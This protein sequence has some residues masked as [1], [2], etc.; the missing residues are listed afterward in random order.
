MAV[1]FHSVIPSLSTQVKVRG[2]VRFVTFTAKDRPYGYGYLH[3]GDPEMIAAIKKHPYFGKYITVAQEDKPAEQEANKVS[4]ST[5]QESK[6]VRKKED[7]EVTKTQEAKEILKNEYD[8]PVE[9]IRSKAAAHVAAE[10]VG[11]SF[12]NL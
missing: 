4:G 10:E 6:E 2:R 7:P 11:I 9:S 3:V 12:P 8:Y 1:V 5:V